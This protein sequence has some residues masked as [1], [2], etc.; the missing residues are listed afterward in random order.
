MAVYFWIP[1]AGES[2]IC[3]FYN[4]KTGKSI[5]KEGWICLWAD[6]L[7]YCLFF[8]ILAFGKAEYTGPDREKSTGAII[9]SAIT[10]GIGIILLVLEVIAVVALGLFAVSDLTV[11]QTQDAVI[12]QEVPEEHRKNQM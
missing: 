5:W 9:A 6:F 12:S 11:Q 1:A 3:N 2:D 8:P 7:K 4:D 10:G